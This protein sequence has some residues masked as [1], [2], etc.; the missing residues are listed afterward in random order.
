[1]IFGSLNDT[2]YARLVRLDKNTC[3]SDL[4]QQ[5]EWVN[6]VREHPLVIARGKG[7][8]L[9]DT[10]GRKYL[11][12]V[13]SLWCNL[14]GHNHPALN[15]AVQRQLNRVAHTTFLGL[16]HEPGIRLA[17]ELTRLA[18][19][20]LTR[21]FYS[22]NG[23]TSVEVALKMAYQYHRQKNPHSR[24]TEF[25][26][27]QNS[28]HGDTIG[29][30]SVGGIGLFHRLFRP[31]LFKTHFAMSPHCQQCPFNRRKTGGL[32]SYIYGNENPKPGDYR[33]QTGCRW[34]CLSSVENF[35]KKRAAKIAAAVV[36][37]VVQGASG[38]L[39]MPPGW[40]KGF[41]RL[42]RKYDIL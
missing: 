27:L 25:V 24:R 5:Q 12:G 33:A 16:T 3:A 42:C 14:L 2:H 11:D 26:A 31:L 6:E 23:S 1:M 28:Y 40:L 35:F 10:Q 20:N 21:V 38:I 8:Y 22:D 29:S 32:Y 9:Y 37:P 34:E 18:P 4:T 30:V 13:S 41:E 19:K 39:V 15:R 7:V 36:E 17:K